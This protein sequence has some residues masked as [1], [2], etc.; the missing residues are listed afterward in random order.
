MFHAFVI[1]CAVNF[2]G[3]DESK[4]IGFDDTWGPYRTE[5]NCN[6]RA[7]Q[8]VKET[9]EGSLNSII[10]AILGYPPVIHSEGYCKKAEESLI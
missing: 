7:N 8:M 4:C 5:E 10:I 9:I 2:A 1:V 3:I 6:I